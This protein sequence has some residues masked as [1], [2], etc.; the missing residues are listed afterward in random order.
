M[1][2]KKLTPEQQREVNRYYEKNAKRLHNM[3]DKIVGRLGFIGLVDNED[4][5]SLANE[6]FANMIEKYDKE[7]SFDIF[8]YSCLLN[9]FKTE[10]TRRNRIKRTSDRL[11]ISLET[12]IGDE[13]DLI[14]EDVLADKNDVESV[15]FDESEDGYSKKVI[16][17]LNRL[18]PLQRKVL[19]LLAIKY[20]NDEIKEELDITDDQLSN[21]LTAIRSQRRSK[22][23]I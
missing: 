6:I 2:Q 10:M 18:S 11:A 22:V 20:T 16:T 1:E 21:C 8:L 19:D 17:Y 4:F 12:P 9:K 15:V 13:D 5:Y 14:L 3:V 7:K 23:L